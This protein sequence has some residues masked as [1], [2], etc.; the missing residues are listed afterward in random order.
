[1][2][3]KRHSTVARQVNSQNDRAVQTRKAKVGEGDLYENVNMSAA[4]SCMVS[5]GVLRIEKTSILF[6]E[7]GTKVNS[8]HYNSEHVLRRI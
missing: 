1:M 6:V 3:T 4:V 8:G 2:Q 5:I 7:L